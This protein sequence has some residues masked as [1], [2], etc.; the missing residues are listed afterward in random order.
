MPANRQGR[1]RRP[2]GKVT[3][4]VAVCSDVSFRISSLV[5]SIG[6]ASV[7]PLFISVV[8]KL[9]ATTGVVRGRCHRSLS[10]PAGV[11]AE[12]EAAE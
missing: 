12:S 4:V 3:L 9:S 5:I 2:A 11:R 8:A 7:S 10:L 6:V 1:S